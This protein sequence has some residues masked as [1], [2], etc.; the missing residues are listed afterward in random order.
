LRATG[1]ISEGSSLS[2][3]S[4]KLGIC[5]FFFQIAQ[6]SIDKGNKNPSALGDSLPSEFS[7]QQIVM[8]L[9]L[10]THDALP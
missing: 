9:G 3:A 2:R 7:F 1:R 5:P 10:R 4:G 6:G 8:R